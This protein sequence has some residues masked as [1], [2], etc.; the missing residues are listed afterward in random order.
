MPEMSMDVEQ[1]AVLEG[2]PWAEQLDRRTRR[3]RMEAAARLVRRLA[4]DFGNILTGILGFSELALSQQ[5]ET[6]SPVHLYLTEIH[7]GAQNGAE[8]TDQLRLF[9]RR[10]TTAKRGCR[11]ADVLG[12]LRG[13][14]VQFQLHLPTDLPPVAVESDALRQVLTIVLDNARE[15]IAGPGVI[16]ISAET[17]Q[18][19]AQEAGE[20]FGD[21]RPG[22]HLEI[23][24]ADNGSGLTPEAQRLLFA[25]PFFSTK[26][27]KRGF[28]LAMAYGILTGHRGGM[29]LLDRPE[30]GTI[31]RLIVPVAV[32]AAP[33]L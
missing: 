33:S 25:E 5:A 18:V 26:S 3:E 11:L 27:R 4:H 8:Y 19:D 30:G 28:G 24:I 16:E 7:R 17:V 10:H 14:D 22:T 23:R 13:K 20:L 32:V 1:A 21:V 2:A 12:E 15:A 9:A 29:E 31:A 6:D